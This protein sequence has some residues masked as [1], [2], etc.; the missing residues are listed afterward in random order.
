MNEPPPRSSLAQ[1]Y[2]RDS[3]LYLLWA[4]RRPMLADRIRA[5]ENSKPTPP[6]RISHD[7]FN[8][9]DGQLCSLQVRQWWGCYRISA[10]YN[11]K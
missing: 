3:L 11:L 6:Q 2:A 1:F 8:G 5:T 10:A 9:I 7:R 4:Q